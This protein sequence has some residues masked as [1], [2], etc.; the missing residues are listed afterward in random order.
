M[1]IMK[2]KTVFCLGILT[3]LLLCMCGGCGSRNDAEGS[4]SIVEESVI[5]EKDTQKEDNQSEGQ[6]AL[7]ETQPGEDLDMIFP[8]A[9]DDTWYKTGDIYTDE[10]GRRLEVLYDDEGM[11]QFAVDGLSL[12]NTM[13]DHF[14]TENNWRI[15][16]CD[17][18]TTV[19]YYPGTPA[20]LEITDGEYAGVYEADDSK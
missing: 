8:A 12:Y 14:Q 19:V 2:E 1:K 15:Y 11:L 5:Q 13:A 10:N 3:A 7:E 17:D 18:G 6:D 9:A 16:T 4:V 20:H